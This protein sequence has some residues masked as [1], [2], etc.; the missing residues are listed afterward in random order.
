LYINQLRIATVHKQAEE[1][2]AETIDSLPEGFLYFDADD[3]LVLFNSKIADIYPL[4]AD[5]FVPGVSFETCMRTGQWSPGDGEDKDEWIR[6]RLAYHYDPKG[7]FEFNLTDGRCIR[8]EEK[9]TPQGG[10]VGMRPDIT[11]LKKI[12]RQL[13]DS[14]ERFRAFS[15]IPRQ[16]YTSRTKNN[17]MCWSTSSLKTF[18][19][20]IPKMSLER[21]PSIYFLRKSPR[22]SFPKTKRY[23]RAGRRCRRKWRL[24]LKTANPLSS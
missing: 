23:C 16:L 3:R 19:A 5:V 17:V 15:K 22:I 20:L 1:L 21:H 24:Y 7:T 8:V 12:E 18:M 10:I 14:E 6:E 11:D 2:L 4:A 9:N 13:R